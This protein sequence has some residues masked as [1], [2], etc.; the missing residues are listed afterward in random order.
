MQHDFKFDELFAIMYVLNCSF[1]LILYKI[2]RE[3]SG[4]CPKF[5]LGAE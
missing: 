3:G 4:L 1:V 2:S 5:K